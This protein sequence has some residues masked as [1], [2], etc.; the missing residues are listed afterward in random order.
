MEIDIDVLLDE[1]FLAELDMGYD[2]RYDSFYCP[3]TVEWLED[4]SPDCEEVRPPFPRVFRV[5]WDD[6]RPWKG[7][8]FRNNYQLSS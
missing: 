6:K 1:D 3:N 5:V 4:P 7:R 2:S 8:T